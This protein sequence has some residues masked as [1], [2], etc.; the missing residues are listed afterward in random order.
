VFSPNQ[1]PKQQDWQLRLD[2]NSF[3]HWQNQQH[4]FFLF[5]DGAATGNLGVAGAGGV[6]YDSE[7][8]KIID[9]AWGLGRQKTIR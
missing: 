7:D 5:F 2:N 3:L 1:V 6:I 8:K 4:S 9:Y